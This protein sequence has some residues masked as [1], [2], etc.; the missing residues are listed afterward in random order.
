[1]DGLEERR[2]AAF[3]IDVAGGS[4]ADGS[5]AGG[6]E[7]GEDVAEEVGG[8]DDVEAVGVEDEVRGEDVDV[9]LVP[10]DGGEVFGT[11]RARARPSR[12]W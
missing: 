10:G 12:A 6:A 4:D 2:E 7:V 8:D 11:S 5:G 9:V 3:R 1:M